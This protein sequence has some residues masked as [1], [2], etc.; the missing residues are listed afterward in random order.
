MINALDNS[1]AP[2]RNDNMMLHLANSIVH[3]NSV[4][5]S[6]RLHLHA[7]DDDSASTNGE[8]VNDSINAAQQYSS[9]GRRSDFRF[10]QL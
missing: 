6:S 4:V 3:L 2:S 5:Q 9:S 1:P 8:N 10:S 7:A